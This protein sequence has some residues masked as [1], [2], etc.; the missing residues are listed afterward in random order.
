MKILANDGI[1]PRGKQILEEAGFTVDTTNIP[2]A[3]LA[4]RLYE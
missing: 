3:E 4:A 1:D 2:Q